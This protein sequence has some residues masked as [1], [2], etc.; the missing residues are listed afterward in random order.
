M[1][2]ARKD[3]Q[4]PRRAAA[5]FQCHIKYKNELPLPVVAPY[6][7]DASLA[8]AAGDLFPAAPNALGAFTLAHSPY[9]TTA[10]EEGIAHCHLPVD[11]L[12]LRALNF[13]DLDAL[14]G[15]GTSAGTGTDIHAADKELLLPYE[16]ML[17]RSRATGANVS[18]PEHAQAHGQPAASTPVSISTTTPISTTPAPLRSFPRPEVTWLRRTEYISAARQGRSHPASAPEAARDEMQQV[19]AAPADWPQLLDAV[20]AS[21]AACA[22]APARHPARPG[23]ALA[24]SFCVLPDGARPVPLARGGPLTHGLFLGDPASG[25]ELAASGTD[26]DAS[27]AI[28]VQD[29]APAAGPDDPVGPSADAPALACFL[30]DAAHATHHY[31]GDFELQ[32]GPA[33]SASG[34]NWVLLLPVEAS[35]PTAFLARIDSQCSLRKRRAAPGAHAHPN[36]TVLRQ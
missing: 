12:R 25:I 34:R 10:L 19:L 23:V 14:A 8:L 13:V 21:F 32:R 28:L 30:P 16:E 2:H 20:E 5:E 26:A 3:A 4:R 22:Q 24:Q 11:L 33:V 18:L 31:A 9:E 29:T 1:S 6:L 36:L 27:A 17:R 35:V 7:L 15:T